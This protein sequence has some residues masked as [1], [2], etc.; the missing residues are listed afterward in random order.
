MSVKFDEGNWN[1]TFSV[2]IKFMGPAGEKG[3]SINLIKVCG[4]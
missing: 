3:I 2:K 4:E 1:K